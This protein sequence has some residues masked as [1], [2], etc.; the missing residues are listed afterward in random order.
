MGAFKLH[1]MLRPF[2]MPV[3]VY[4][5]SL[6]LFSCG[7]TAPTA[8]SLENP[9]GT[10]PPS[11][12][13]ANILYTTDTMQCHGFIAYDQ[14]RQGKLPVV[15]IVHEWWGLTDYLKTRARQLAGLGYFAIAADMYGEGRTASNP[16]E[17]LAMAKPYY[18]NPYIIKNRLA[19]A[20]A[21][22]GTFSQADTTRVAAM[23]YCFGG[24]VVLNAAKMGL[25]L[26]GTV[27][28]HGDLSGPA[29]RRGA[30][31]GEMLICQ[32]GS[33]ELVPEAQRVAFRK[34]MDSAGVKYLFMTYPGASHAFTNPAATE[35]GEKFHM[36]V[37]YNPTADS[38]SWSDM[39]N[40]FS[41][42]LK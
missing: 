32:G 4:F 16:T 18:V 5:F 21:K 40:F 1:H 25:P 27:S 42:V 13:T 26:K 41:S 34:T 10:K 14:N 28:F 8:G 7:N 30:V 11:I 33:D 15:V 37:A 9:G 29:P 38:A 17:A 39:K 19:A 36:P 23:G 12:K 31:T 20:I 24:F 2:L 35:T 3:A 6:S 22:A